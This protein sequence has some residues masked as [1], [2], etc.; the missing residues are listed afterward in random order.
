MSGITSSGT[1]AIPEGMNPQGMNPVLVIP[2]RVN[3]GRASREPKAS[4][5]VLAEVVTIRE[6]RVGDVAD[7]A[8]GLL[9]DMATSRS[10]VRRSAGRAAVTTSS[11]V[12]GAGGRAGGKWVPNNP[13]RLTFPGQTDKK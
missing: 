8:D 9:G 7:V 13:G 11:T 10:K 2:N 6:C 3:R 12:S 1:R 5:Q 4:V